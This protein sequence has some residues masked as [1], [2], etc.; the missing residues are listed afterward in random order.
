M[1]VRVN[2]FVKIDQ[3]V[4]NLSI[5]SVVFRNIKRSL[6]NLPYRHCSSEKLVKIPVYFLKKKYVAKLAPGNNKPAP[7]F[8]PNPNIGS[9]GT[10]LICIAILKSI[11]LH[12]RHIIVSA[13]DHV[14]VPFL[15][16]SCMQALV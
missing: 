8:N 5:P 4:Q 10:Y 2:P 7:A 3:I 11:Y 9:F 12:I 16:V 1:C 15:I 13:P 6:F 14:I